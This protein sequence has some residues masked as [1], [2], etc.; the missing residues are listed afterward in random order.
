[1]RALLTQQQAMDVTSHNIANLNTVGYTRQRAHLESV[2]P[3]GMPPVGGGVNM[4]SVER[5]RDLFMDLQLRTESSAEGSY[6]VQADS[7]ALAEVALGEPGEG[8]IRQL[9]SSFF[10]AWRDL[11]NAPEESAARQAVVQTGNSLAL[12]A[13]RVNR[14]FTAL[15]ED[16][17]QRISLL[18]TET[19]ALGEEIA[20]LNQQIMALRGSGDAASDLTDRRDLALDRLAQIADI[21][22]LERENGQTDVYIAGRALVSGTTSNKMY[23]DPNIANSNYFDVRWETDNVLAKFGSGEIHGLL[24]QRDADMPA[25][26]ADFNTFVGQLITDINGLHSAGFAADGVTTA[27]VF[28]SG[29]DATDI[30]VDAAIVGDPTLIAAATLPGAPGDASNA[31]GIAALQFAQNLAGG[32]QSY[33][34]F[35]GGLVTTLGTDARDTQNVAESQGMLMA[36]IEGFRQS[37][38]GVNLDEEMV[39]MV[40]YQRAY[41]AA[42]QIIRKIDEMLDHLIN[43]T[44]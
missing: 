41:E 27:Q 18:V 37:V 38:S 24:V 30:V 36:Q 2:S 6:R 32:T 12:A 16:A 15:Q 29:T 13:Q 8:G 25:R 4:Q 39:S 20:G 3:V 17:N 5:V 10:N 31:H 40:Q 34:A 7:L 28:F 1:M 11:A 21:Q 35:Y 26:I 22:Y 33:E 43:R 44:I 9:L 19:N 42:A 14:T 23:V